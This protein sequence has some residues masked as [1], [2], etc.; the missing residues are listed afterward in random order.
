M[1]LAYTAVDLETANPSRGSICQ[2][3][4]S[5]VR[6]GRIV[7]LHS[8]LVKPHPDVAEFSPVHVRIHRIKPGDVADAPTLAA[9]WPQMRQIIGDDLLVAHNAVFERSCLQQAAAL[10]GLSPLSGQILCTVDLARAVFPELPRHKLPIVLDRLGLT[11]TA[12]HDAS[13]DAVDAA[14]ILAGCAAHVGTDQMPELLART[15]V[16]ARPMAR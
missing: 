7:A 8:Q 9:I 12:H 5:K 6:D 11:P 15:R 1:T 14:R 13:S 3:G 4:L 2:I 16:C 10:A